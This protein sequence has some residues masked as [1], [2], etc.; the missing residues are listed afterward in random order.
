MSVV[1]SSEET[2]AAASFCPS[3]R[4][5]GADSCRC[6]CRTLQKTPLAKKTRMLHVGAGGKGAGLSS[7]VEQA[8]SVSVFVDQ[9]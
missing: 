2:P 6:L 8:P 3:H 4:G 5:S 1:K 9:P 7:F